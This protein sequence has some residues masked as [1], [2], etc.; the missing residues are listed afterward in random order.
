M[1][2]M[3]AR[4]KPAQYKP[5]NSLHIRVAVFAFDGMIP[6]HLFVPSTVF[7]TGWDGPSPYE[8]AFFALSAGAIRTKDGTDIGISYDLT[9]LDALGPDDM[10]IIPTWEDIETRPDERLLQALQRAA[11]R[12][13]TIVGLC[14]GAYILAEAGL[15]DHRRATT[16]WAFARHF[17]QRFPLVDLRPDTLYED[18]GTIVTSA[19]VAAGMDCCL[20][21]LRRQ[22]GA[23]IANKAA[24]RL[25]ISPH[26]AGG[27]AQ[28]IE[29]PV[30]TARGETKLAGLLDD[31]RNDLTGVYDIDTAAAR[32][33]ISRRSFT[34][35][36]L[37]YTGL[38]FTRWLLAERLARSQHL[39]ESTNLSIDAIAFEAGFG[40]TVSLR[41]HFRQTFA[42]SPAQWR[43]AFRGSGHSA[44]DKKR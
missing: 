37:R 5:A 15:L 6:F 14:L 3:P 41:H 38:S 39:L 2:K 28:F 10:I 26:R 30:P 24:R 20:H 19:G 22:W 34:R 16:H 8:I 9:L 29:K 44:S 7:C 27:Q 4:Y 12:K 13:V 32:L 31:I 42:V 25:V 11:K 40:S 23:D 35:Q 36:F 33:G 1:D 21:L 17:A 18:E 43:K